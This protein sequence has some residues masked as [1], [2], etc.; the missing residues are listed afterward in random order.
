MSC[1]YTE[2]GNVAVMSGTL[3]TGLGLTSIAGLRPSLYEYS[4]GPYSAPNATDCSVVYVLKLSTAAGTST[5][6][7]PT[8]NDVGYQAAKCSSGSAHTVEPTYTTIVE[9]PF[10]INQRASFRWVAA[11]GAEITIVGTASNGIGMSANSSNYTGEET[12]T[13]KH[14]E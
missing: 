8:P 9:G 1:Y 4:I 10:G 3:Q 14:R 11:P 6:V 12:M 7:T 13:F 5:S 2:S